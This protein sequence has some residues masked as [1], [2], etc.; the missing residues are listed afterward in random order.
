MAERSILSIV[1]FR[2]LQRFRVAAVAAPHFCSPDAVNRLCA[3]RRGACRGLE[4][5][6][7]QGTY[8]DKSAV[9]ERVLAIVQ[10]SQKVEPS[11]VISTAHFQKDL[12]LDSLDTVEI[13]MA[14][15]EAFD[16]E[17]PDQEAEKFLSC[18]DAIDYIAS[19]PQAKSEHHP[20][21]Q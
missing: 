12:G 7:D 6:A 2:L 1:R 16:I 14:L 11:K 10:N 4:T 8:L 17:I 13:V 18:A 21:A 9:A 19:L 15:E 5:K 3:F 20:N